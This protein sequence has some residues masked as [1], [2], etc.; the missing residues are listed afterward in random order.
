M[1]TILLLTILF[2]TIMIYSCSQS[3]KNQNSLTPNHIVCEWKVNE[4][5]SISDLI[6]SVEY[7]PLESHP[8]GLFKAIDKLMVRNGKYFIFDC[9]GQNQVMVFDSTGK[10]LFPVGKKGRAPGEYL[11]IRNFTV[12]DNCVYLINNDANTLMIYD[13]TDGHFVGQKK[14]PFFAFDVS[15]CDN[16]DLIFSWYSNKE[17][18]A[19]DEPYKIMV[20]D[21]EINIQH[22]LFGINDNDC[23][24]LSKRHYF[25]SSASN[26]VFNTLFSDTIVVFS[27]QAPEIVATYSMDFKSRKI[28]AN[29]RKSYVDAKLF[30]YL[31][32]TPII[33]SQYIIGEMNGENGLQLFVY[34]IKKQEAYFNCVGNE[35]FMLSPLVYN[36][37]N[38]I[39]YTEVFGLYE[40]FVKQGLKRAPQHVE[41]KLANGDYA[42]IKYKLK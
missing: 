12:D 13:N 8:D 1:K 37:G 17:G 23:N 6:D 19:N 38:V 32:E 5:K 9:F 14:L 24:D 33:T 15:V 7:V 10:F 26:I 41:E 3:S 16:N 34:D 30:N 29:K 25:M 4:N 11:R 20:T 2:C 40:N 39:G 36:D 28:P 42:L 27:R 18:T 21:K 22:N 31:S 35:H